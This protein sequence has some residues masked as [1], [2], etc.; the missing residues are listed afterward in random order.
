MSEVRPLIFTFLEKYD[1][2][3]AKKFKGHELYVRTSKFT[4]EKFDREKIKQSLL[5]ETEISEDAAEIITNEVENFIR[6][7]KYEIVSSSLIRE[8]VNSRLLVHGLEKIRAEYTRIGMPVWDVTTLINQGSNENANLQ[9]NPET[10][11]KLIADS[12]L[13][14]YT[15]IK[16]LPKHIADSHLRGEIHIHDLDYFALRPF[17]FSHDMRFFLKRGYI[18]D[19]QGIH[20]ATA[21]PAKHPEVAVLH[22][23]KFLASSQTNCAGGQG[24]NWFNVL[25]S[26]YLQGLSYERIKQLAQMFLFEMSQ[27]YVARGGQTVFSS[28]DIEPEVPSVLKNVPAVLPGGIVKE[29]VTYENFQDETNKFFKAIIEVYTQ[30]DA[31]KKPFNFPK[32]EVKVSKDIIEKYKEEMFAVAELAAKFGTPYFFVQQDYMPEYSCYQ[33]CSYLMDLSNQNSESDLYNGTVRGGALQVATLNLPRIAYESRGDDTKLFELIRERLEIIRELMFI[34][35]HIIKKRLKQGIL[36][37]LSQ[38]VNEKG[39]TYLNPDK[40]SFEIGMIGLNEMLK[41]HLGYE[42]HESKDAWTF[43][44]RVIKEMCDIAKEFNKT[45]EI[46]GHFAISRTPAESCSHRLAK[47]DFKEFNGRA[48]VQGDKN[49]GAIYYTNSTH[50][51]PSAEISIWDRIKIESSFHPLLV[52]GAM[53]HIWLGEAFPNPQAIFELNKK[54][55]NNTLTAY[56]AYTKDLTVCR[57]CNFVYGQATKSCINCGSQEVDIY[58]RITGY[59]QNLGSWNEGKKAEFFERKRYVIKEV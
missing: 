58:S 47:I 14:E 44:L 53:L 56:Y 18:S 52:G 17:C 11:H 40:M 39:D 34:K 24:Y 27:M 4:Y 59:Y 28:I 51:R 10:I 36:P 13:K 43:G 19:G 16:L 7:A 32:C 21:G 38:P 25:L 35:Y 20:T 42:L 48:I 54:I 31:K 6:N 8:L 50:I 5:R 37:F 30:G 57:K 2:I 49:S 55:I 26:P 23:A 41:A 15:L 29:N 45:N 22:A 46:G 1:P 9:Y 33:C 12:I 3:S